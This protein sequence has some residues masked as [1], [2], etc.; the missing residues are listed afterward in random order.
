MKKVVIL[1]GDREISIITEGSYTLL[2][3]ITGRIKGLRVGGSAEAFLRYVDWR[4][5][6]AVLEYDMDEQDA[7][8]GHGDGTQAG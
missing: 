7:K 3:G 2:R 5:V 6:L 4:R 8:E 1:F